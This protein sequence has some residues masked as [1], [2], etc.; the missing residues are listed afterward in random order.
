MPAH[1]PTWLCVL[2][3]SAT[4]SFI[5]ACSLLPACLPA[6]VCCMLCCVACAPCVLQDVL[7]SMPAELEFLIIVAAYNN[8]KKQGFVPPAVCNRELDLYTVRCVFVL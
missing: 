7:A 8:S 1:C 6:A 2:W 5:P 3:L 4:L